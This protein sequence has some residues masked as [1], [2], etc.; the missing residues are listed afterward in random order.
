MSPSPKQ[1]Y[2]IRFIYSPSLL[3]TYDIRG[4]SQSL[5]TETDWDYLCLMR[6][7]GEGCIIELTLGLHTPLSCGPKRLSSTFFRD[8]VV[9]VGSRGFSSLTCNEY[10]KGS[11]Q[12]HPV[13]AADQNCLSCVPRPGGGPA[14]VSLA[15]QGC[16]MSS[17]WES[18]FER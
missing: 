3:S 12:G 9:T 1:Q 11:C 14:L 7:G 15:S 16:S 8:G 10:N 6:V 18:G 17:R 13:C 5:G 2:F 4:P